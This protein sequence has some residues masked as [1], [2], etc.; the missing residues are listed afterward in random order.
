MSCLIFY[1]GTLC[2][3]EIHVWNDYDGRR[4]IST[5]PRHGFDN[6]GKLRRQYD[7]NSIHY[8]HYQL[9]EV[10][11]AQAATFAAPMAQDSEQSH[12]PKDALTEIRAPKEGIMG[13]RELIKLERRGGRYLDQ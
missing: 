3:A 11:A 10:L 5:I 4:T 12:I 6:N 13:L 2:A 1:A 8:Q 9:R 7:P